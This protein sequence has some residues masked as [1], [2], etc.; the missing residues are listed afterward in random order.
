M[1]CQF[2]TIIILNVG[3]SIYYSKKLGLSL[4]AL[5]L[6]TLLLVLSSLLLSLL[7]VLLTLCSCSIITRYGV[8][9]II[10]CRTNFFS[11][12]IYI[13][14]LNSIAP[15]LLLETDQIANPMV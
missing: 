12:K 5:L 4:L 2:S 8:Y 13:G 9:V 14:N 7:I 11:L 15:S 1:R 6:L 3:Y 10:I